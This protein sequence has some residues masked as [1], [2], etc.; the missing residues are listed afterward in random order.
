[1][2]SSV[3]VCSTWI[4]VFIS[5]KKYSP[6]PKATSIVRRAVAHRSGRVH[7]DL[8]DPLARILGHSGRR[9]FDEL[10]VPALDRAVPLAE[11]HDGA[12]RV[13]EHLDLD[14][15]RVIEVP[16]DVD[17]GSEKYASPRGARTRA[18]STSSPWARP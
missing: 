16:L 9:R 8:T 17:A 7:G 11:V 13:G 2:T 1:M 6:S 5:R 12:V 15:A 14:M 4:L 18:R 3:T 10:L